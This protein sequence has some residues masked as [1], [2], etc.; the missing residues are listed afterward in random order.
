MK[1]LPGWL[2]MAAVLLFAL[3]FACIAGAEKPGP[4]VVVK[5]PDHVPINS[6]LEVHIYCDGATEYRH[7]IHY[8]SGGTGGSL[9]VEKDPDGGVVAMVKI[10]GSG[11]GDKYDLKISA[12]VD[13]E[14]T[15]ETVVPLTYVAYGMLDA[16]EYK[17]SDIYFVGQP[18]EV[19]IQPV[20]HARYYIL[21]Y[22]PLNEQGE[23]SSYTEIITDNIHVEID[24]D[25]FFPG[26]YG[27][28]VI[29]SA[30]GWFKP[31]IKK[32]TV[33]H[34]M[35]SGVHMGPEVICDDAFLYA[36]HE[37][38]FTFR[39]ADATRFMYYF[40]GET[41]PV[42]VYAPNGETT[43]RIYIP[44]PMW[45]DS[46]LDSYPLVV[47]AWHP[48]S[49]KWS[50]PTVK[51]CAV[52]QAV[53]DLVPHISFFANMLETEED[54][55]YG[56]STGMSLA[57][58]A[59]WESWFSIQP[60]ELKNRKDIS[61]APAKFMVSVDNHDAIYEA[62]HE[63]EPVWTIEQIQG[64]KIGIRLEGMYGN[65]GEWIN[66]VA[67][68]ERNP[69]SSQ[70]LVYRFT[71][72]WGGYRSARTFTLHY[73]KENLP[74]RTTI[75]EV[76]EM[77]VG[78]PWKINFDFD[79]P[80]T[81]SDMIT[82]YTINFS[83]EGYV[84]FKWLA[85]AV[86]SENEFFMTPLKAGQVFGY[87]TMFN[88]NLSITKK[89]LIRIADENGVVPEEEPEYF[90]GDVNNDEVIDGR[91]AIRLMRFLA[92][93]TDGETGEEIHVH[94]TNSECNG[95]GVIDEKDLLLIMEFLA[96]REGE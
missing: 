29:S 77:Q 16:P 88:N 67:R 62:C 14:W 60:E 75:P 91:D 51:N 61:C 35:E 45:T 64:E 34:R 30:E 56:F 32:P 3:L 52:N 63:K 92:G 74:D 21:E 48:D 50:L 11:D 49:Q 96:E 73:R 44:H 10:G 25:M 86:S 7:D 78:V 76:A 53:Y 1:K 28:K 5:D 82:E 31:D 20:P 57:T 81:W 6:T 2:L 26:T 22:G 13:G 65:D 95:D 85:G 68:L 38:D 80:M 72:T 33:I 54:V 79:P 93:D 66:S 70:D 41:E 69:S 94:R 17:V 89:M 55:G 37:A 15:A 23:M 42:E 9:S 19:D 12:C 36:N 58:G 27:L 84:D 8:S 71:C 39:D 87:V 24:K 4:K 18:V 59:G 43:V 47:R 40:E 83:K 90:P 46:K